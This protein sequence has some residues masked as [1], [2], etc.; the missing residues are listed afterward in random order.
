MGTAVEILA[1]GVVEVEFCNDQG[2]TYATA[3]L[4]P[5]DLVRL[6]HGPREQVA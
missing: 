5:D 1:E 6:H 3:A 4:Q 2:R